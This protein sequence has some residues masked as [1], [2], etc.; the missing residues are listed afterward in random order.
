MLWQ[1]SRKTSRMGKL[2]LS[3]VFQGTQYH[4]SKKKKMKLSQSNGSYSRC[5]GGTSST[6]LEILHNFSVFSEKRRKGIQNLVQEFQNLLSLDK[7]DTLQ[8]SILDFLR[9]EKK[10]LLMDQFIRHLVPSCCYWFLNSSF[11][12]CCAL[13]NDGEAAWRGLSWKQGH[14]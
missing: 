7:I 12:N 1:I 11:A 9:K 5:K 3:M 6:G 13:F 2:L 4:Q 8:S 10:Y 14:L